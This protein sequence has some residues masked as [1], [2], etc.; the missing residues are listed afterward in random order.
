MLIQFD[1]KHYELDLQRTAKLVVDYDKEYLLIWTLIIS[2]GK[3]LTTFYNSIA[4]ACILL[5]CIET[6]LSFLGVL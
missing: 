4:S 5:Q 2:G 1:Y 3:P 6:E